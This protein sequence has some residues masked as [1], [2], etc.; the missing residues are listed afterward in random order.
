MNLKD[1]TV[2]E[3]EARMAAIPADLDKDDADLDAL[4]AEARGIK[5]ELEA[6]KAAEAQ[7]REIREQV[8]VS[9]QKGQKIME[10]TRNVK[11]LEEIRSSKEYVNAYAEYIKTGK[12]A[13]CR[14]LLSENTPNQ[15]DGSVPVP[16][17]VEGRIRTAW[18]KAGVMDIVRKTFIRGNVKVGY[19]ANS[20]SAEVH[21]EGHA[22]PDEEILTLK[23][24]NL[25]PQSIKKWITISDEALDLSGEEFLDYIY[26][27]LAYRIAQKAQEVLLQRIVYIA[28]NSNSGPAVT[29]TTVAQADMLSATVKCLGTLSGEAA[30]PV[31][32]TTR[33]TW[34][35]IKA[36]AIGANYAVDPF[37]GLP[38]YF[39]SQTTLG[40][41]VAIVGDFGY[42]AMAN[43]PNG[44]EIQ[45]KKD[46]LS[47]AE[48]DLVKLVGRQYV[49]L[50]VV[51][52]NA[53]TVAYLGE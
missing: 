12:D 8:A 41:A 14:K 24:A 52:P 49:A 36:A 25:I 46:E 45:I 6:R 19:E 48:Q 39:V 50:D 35:G 32:V 9:E 40:S 44:A 53:F 43:F 10:E 16:T 33:A 7:R 26:D 13:E 20:S 21:V 31:I 17:I 5:E 37:E 47:L 29:K 22:A 2:E 51:A 27:E 42:G 28:N 4:E 3:L 1:M 30:N 11:T 15:T 38:V 18:E 23:V 34:A